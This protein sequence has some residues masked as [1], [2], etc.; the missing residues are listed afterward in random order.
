MYLGRDTKSLDIDVDQSLGS[1]VYDKS[2]VR[3]IDFSTNWC[4]ILGWGLPVV[5]EA[6]RKFHGP[7]YVDPYY[8]YRSWEKLAKILVRI[9]PGQ[10]TSAFRATSGTEAVEIAL[11]AAMNYTKR[12]KFVSDGGYHG[13]SFA[14]L[15][16]GSARYRERF[17]NLLSST[18]IDPPYDRRA[19]IKIAKILSRRRIAAFVSEAIICNRG[20][21]EPTKEYFEIVQSACKK[22]ETVLVI[23]EVATGFG[24][25]GK[26]FASEYY[27][28]TPD[29]LC[30]GK[31][32]TGGNAILSAC[33]MN[34][35]LTKSMQYDF[36]YYSTFAWQPLNVEI[37]LTYLHYFMANQQ[38]ILKKVNTLSLYF[39]ERLSKMKGLYASDVTMKGLAIA[40]HLINGNADRIRDVCLSRGLLIDCLDPHTLSFFPSALM[41]LT[42]ADSGLTTLFQVLRTLDA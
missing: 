26:M 34:E 18:S 12:Y 6:I 27:N 37:T 7:N 32:L 8:Q 10:M 36:S 9:A 5:R 13:H 38:E 41:K 25:T 42:T 19:A 21:I 40:V 11:Q 30:L 20:V 14:T 16:V 28:L 4:G 31:G 23:D 39:R 22:Y 2:G 3:Y 24:R 35:N 29:I 33:L 17:P 15:S 1:F